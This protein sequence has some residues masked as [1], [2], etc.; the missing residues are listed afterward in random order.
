MES[1]GWFSFSLLST[2]S[3]QKVWLWFYGYLRLLKCCFLFQQRINANRTK[4]KSNIKFTLQ[5]KQKTEQLD[6]TQIIMA[7]LF[8]ILKS[9]FLVLLSLWWW[10]CG[11]CC[12]D[13]YSAHLS[14]G[15]NGLGLVI[16]KRIAVMV[17]TDIISIFQLNYARTHNVSKYIKKVSVWELIQIKI[18]CL[19]SFYSHYLPM[20]ILWLFSL[21]NIEFL[22][23]FLKRCKIKK[24]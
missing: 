15:R 3:T 4:A 8:L 9:W 10:W 14:D 20:G 13:R 22:F 5:T 17:V 1:I 21:Y 18:V 11:S 2:K 16:F 24:I 12:S 23:Y 7:F 19:H 6:I